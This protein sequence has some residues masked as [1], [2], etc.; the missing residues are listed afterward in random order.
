VDTGL[1][2]LF[3]AGS[4]ACR[5]LPSAIFEIVPDQAFGTAPKFALNVVLSRL[6]LK[7][8]ALTLVLIN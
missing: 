3:L 2:T 4:L 7:F 5:T 6:Y 1:D 8:L